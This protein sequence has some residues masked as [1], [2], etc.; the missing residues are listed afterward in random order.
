SGGERLVC[1]YPRIVAAA[2]FPG[3]SVANVFS[4]TD[5]QR[6]R[7]PL[8]YQLRGGALEEW[9]KLLLHLDSIPPEQIT[10]GPPCV[11]WPPQPD[12]CFSVSSLRRILAADK[13][14]GDNAF[15]SSVIWQPLVPSKISCLSW[16]IYFRKVATIDNLQKKGLVLVNRCALCVSDLE[17]VD[18]LFTTC[19]FVSEIWTLVSS[20]LSIH[21]PLPSSVVELIKGWK[22]LNCMP[23]F[24]MVMKVLLHAVFWFTWKE[25][26]DRIFRGVSSSPSLT[27]TMLCLAVGD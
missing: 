22:G 24:S 17:S 27:M 12:G 5:R 20:K 4:F 6:W 21:G 7:I 15:P 19:A 3:E 14:K 11:F 2:L 16:K 25:R 26:N 10:E 13:F 9:H 18:H 1:V 8:R 23:S